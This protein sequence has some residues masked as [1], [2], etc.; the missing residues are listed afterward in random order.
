ML[1]GHPLDT[2]KVRLQSV[3]GASKYSGMVDCARQTVQT[4]GL[5]GFYRGMAPPL[6]MAGIL[7]GVMFSVNGQMKRAVAWQSGKEIGQLGA[8]EVV[9]AALMTAPVYCAVLAPTELVKARLQFQTAGSEQVYRG[10]AD[11]IRKVVTE[12]GV[13]GLWQG[14]GVTVLTR[15][16]GAP[17]YFV[18]YDV[19]SKRFKGD[20]QERVPQ[21][22][23]LVAGGLAG[24]A[25]WTGNFP[26]MLDCF[27]SKQSPNSRNHIRYMSDHACTT[28]FHTI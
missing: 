16:V 7:N 23:V 25:F 21:W 6:V 26:G 2:I 20:D 13:R 1:V 15:I 3:H 18:V 19:L 28:A 11:V 4:E 10:P 12:A 17:C 14:Y 22:K 27:S 9:A 5:R 8:L 24:V